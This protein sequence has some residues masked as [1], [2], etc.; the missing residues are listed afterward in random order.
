MPRLLQFLSSETGRPVVAKTGLA[1]LTFELHW[2]P[3]QAEPAPDSPPG[4]F[5]AVQEQL[6]L[7]LEPGRGQVEMIVID[8]VQRPTPN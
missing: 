8:S 3:A 6:G 5:T 2:L 7:K 1:E 4:L